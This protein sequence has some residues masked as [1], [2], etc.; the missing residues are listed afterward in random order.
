MAIYATTTTFMLGAHRTILYLSGICY[1]MS[2]TINPVL[3]SIMS[4][5]FRKAFKQT[6]MNCCC[7]RKQ[8]RHRPNHFSYKFVH[9]NGHTETS[10]TSVGPMVHAGAATTASHPLQH[11]RAQRDRHGDHPLLP[12][13]SGTSSTQK[14]DSLTRSISGSSLKSTDEICQE[15]EDIQ[16]VLFQIKCYDSNRNTAELVIG[17]C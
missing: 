1:F 5:K 9:R 13:S 17:V 11:Q 3:Y 6:L 14:K 7:C 12:H 16:Q 4:L 15:E 2:G 10:Y 8:T